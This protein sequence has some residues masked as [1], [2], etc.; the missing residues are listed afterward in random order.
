MESTGV[1]K[2]YRKDELTGRGREKKGQPTDTVLNRV[3]G[4]DPSKGTERSDE[5]V[6]KNS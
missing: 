3:P 5:R 6:G 4:R 1:Q 2:G